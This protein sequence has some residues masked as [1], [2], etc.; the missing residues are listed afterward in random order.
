MQFNLIKIFFLAIALPAFSVN[1]ASSQD[2][3]DK[4]EDFFKKYVTDGRVAY[5]ELSTDDVMKDLLYDIEHYSMSGRSKEYKAAFYLN[6][7]NLLVI[8]TI[9]DNWPVRNVL[10]IE[11]IFN[12][13]TFKVAGEELTLNDIENNKLRSD[14][15][16]DRVHFALVCGAVSCP[17][18]PSFSFIP[19]ALH[20]QLKFLT[21]EALKDPAI[22]QFDK[23]NNTLSVS[24]I[25]EWYKVDFGDSDQGIIEYVEDYSLQ[26]LP[27]DIQLIYLEYDWSVNGQ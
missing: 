6:A 5:A 14:Y 15:G 21:A 12:T 7:Y 2:F 4:A 13:M 3:F 17:K 19:D 1:T 18:L 10:G 22:I 11:G 8:H 25:F 23:D 27:G 16:D 20:Q 9:Q 26:D 24:R